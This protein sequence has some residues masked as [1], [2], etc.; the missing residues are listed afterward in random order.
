VVL[1]RRSSAKSGANDRSKGGNN[2]GTSNERKGKRGKNITIVVNA[3]S[4]SPA[5]PSES[6]SPA[7]A[8]ASASGK[9][10][11]RKAVERS[12]SWRGPRSWRDGWQ[13]RYEFKQPDADNDAA[14]AAAATDTSTQ[15]PDTRTTVMIKNIPNKYRSSC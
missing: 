12:G 11:C 4:S 13:T 10:Q 8:T 6:S 9:Q 1:L 3:T 5:S 15:E 14:T 7:S 2:A